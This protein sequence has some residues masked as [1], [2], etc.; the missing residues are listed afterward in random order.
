[1]GC[2]PS[3]ERLAA[4]KTESSDR[5]GLMKREDSVKVRAREELSSDA[6]LMFRDMTPP[7]YDSISM[8]MIRQVGR[9]T[10]LPKSIATQDPAPLRVAEPASA[11]RSASA[12]STSPLV[13]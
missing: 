7:T 12:L 5:V 6:E 11:E 3:L 1:M 10:S 9:P 8:A 13:P 4:A 2:A